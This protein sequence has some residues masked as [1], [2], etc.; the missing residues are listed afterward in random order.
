ML[1][2]SQDP[3]MPK[4]PD[5]PTGEPRF[6]TNRLGGEDERDL[7][8][9]KTMQPVSPSENTDDFSDSGIKTAGDDQSLGAGNGPEINQPEDEEEGGPGRLG[10]GSL[11]LRL[12]GSLR[13]VT[14]PL[15]PTDALPSKK[16]QVV[17]PPE[18]RSEIPVQGI[19]SAVPQAEESAPGAQSEAGASQPPFEE[20]IGLGRLGTGSLV[21]RLTGTLRRVTGPLRPTDALPPKQAQSVPLPEKWHD[22]PPPVQGGEATNVPEKQEPVPDKQAQSGVTQPLDE[23]EIHPSRLG[24]GSLVQRLTGTLRRVTGP[25]GVTDSLPPKEPQPVS[26]PEKRRDVPVQ[27]VDTASLPELDELQPGAQAG[28]EINS[29]QDEEGIGPARLGTGS[30]VQRL[31][32]TLRRVTGPLNPT[33]ALPPKGYQPASPEKRH[34][35][36]IQKIDTASLPELQEPPPGT[37]AEVDASLPP[38][39][40]EMD[41]SRLGTGSLIQ[42]LTGTLRRVTGPLHPTGG[43]PQQGGESESGTIEQPHGNPPAPE[44]TWSRK[45]D[46]IVTGQLGDETE[47]EPLFSQE[48]QPNPLPESRRQV[49]DS[50]IVTGRL[51]GLDEDLIIG[52]ESEPVLLPE[53]ERSITPVERGPI[54]PS[55]E[56]PETRKPEVP[57]P[58][59]KQ[60]AGPDY[61][62][63]IRQTL[64]NEEPDRPKRWTG[65]LIQRFTGTLRRITSPLRATDSLPEEQPLPPQETIPQREMADDFLT[66]RLGG[67]QVDE[68]PVSENPIGEETLPIQLPESWG[69]LPDSG[70]EAAELLEM[71][72]DQMAGPEIEPEI[73]LGDVEPISLLESGAIAALGRAEE[74]SQ[75]EEEPDW[76]AEIRKE[77]A[78]S[79]EETEAQ[80]TAPVTDDQGASIEPGPDQPIDDQSS[81]RGSGGQLRNFFTGMLGRSGEKRKQET[82]ETEFPDELMTGRLSRSLGTEDKQ[83]PDLNGEDL[84]AEIETFPAAESEQLTGLET[85]ESDIVLSPA[86]EEPPLL[87]GLEVRFAYIDPIPDQAAPSEEFAPYELYPED[88]ILLWGDFAGEVGTNEVDTAARGEAPDETPVAPDDIWA[89]GQTGAYGYGADLRQEIWGEELKPEVPEESVSSAEPGQYVASDEYA[90]EYLTGEGTPPEGEGDAVSQTAGEDKEMSVQD[91]R[92][93]ALEDYE[94]GE[95]DY[96]AYKT[97]IDW[98]DEEETAVAEPAEEQEVET[99]G[100]ETK[101]K[102]EVEPEAEEEPA[103]A[104][105]W[106]TWLAARNTSQKLLLAEGVL[107]VL[108][109]LVAIPFFIFMIIRGP[110]KPASQLVPNGLP[111]GVPTPIGLTLPGGWYFQLEKSTITDGKWQPVTS[112]WWEGTELR[113]VVALPWNAQTEAVIK[114]FQAGNSVELNLSNNTALKY[115]IA[116]IERVPVENT[117][118]YYDTRPSLAIILYSENASSRWVVICNP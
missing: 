32:G 95:F 86:E 114:T 29:S 47:N 65:S 112:E 87:E 3:K 41:V 27:R 82:E 101:G 110:M 35:I 31:T 9:P 83:A 99:P 19:E 104:E 37:R 44:T 13:R 43:V 11:V 18:K 63:E 92:S 62:S 40:D 48:Q 52:T 58:R 14:G 22:V 108:A 64:T 1:D 80:Y 17:P 69:E 72:E 45:S 12:T 106:R 7:L 68:P 116:T 34:D 38:A 115:K 60:P 42:R 5:E 100:V 57:A 74:A 50:G 28:P 111:A 96:S 25:L 59:R 24:T 98:G 23:E 54:L 113:R 79:A 36:P 84:F 91:L 94:E 109:M 55:N 49:P 6:S 75:E 70:I 26:P 118:I 90:A 76:M 4:P 117:Q 78:Q 51:Q 16:P 67:V 85:G 81:R 30:L 46:P 88:E 107:V 89:R 53:G 71:E 102:A 39:E 103:Q 105:D 66:D 8:V 10:T 61:I 33:D 77:A 97:T 73:R 15:R 2:D 56:I 93:I 20:E 21:Q